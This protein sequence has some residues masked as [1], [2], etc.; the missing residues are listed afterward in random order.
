[1]AGVK[2]ASGAEYNHTV[3][4]L[5]V[6]GFNTVSSRSH[7]ENVASMWLRAVIHA[8]RVWSRKAYTT[9]ECFQTE[10][11]EKGCYFGEAIREAAE[12]EV[13]GKEE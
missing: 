4:F 8:E 9:F 12:R 7:P 11:G 6:L 2:F 10:F 13:W 1:M 3:I 5:N